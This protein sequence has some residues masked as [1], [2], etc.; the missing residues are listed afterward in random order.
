M[1]RLIERLLAD[2]FDFGETKAATWKLP[3]PMPELAAV[4][5]A[6]DHLEWRLIGAGESGVEVIFKALLDAGLA[7]AADDPANMD[8]KLA[9]YQAALSDMPA[10]LMEAAFMRCIKESQ[11]FPQVAVFRKSIDAEFSERRRMLDRAKRIREAIVNPPGPNGSTFKPEEPHVRLAGMIASFTRHGMPA[12]A[13]RPV[14]DLF[15][16]SEAEKA[17]DAPASWATDGFIDVPLKKLDAAGKWIDDPVRVMIEPPKF[18][19]IRA[20]E[21]PMKYP[22]PTQSVEP[23]IEEPASYARL[24]SCGHRFG[25]HA[26]EGS[27]TALDCRCLGFEEAPPPRAEEDG[28]APLDW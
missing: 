16:L 27:C 24:C 4:Q 25:V 2:P 11:F 14:A 18:E 20:P 26:D 10:D 5:Q 12:R 8:T 19:D 23:P 15:A 7:M 22:V 17:K 21:E 28:G 3:E 13:A 6:V 9:I 1:P